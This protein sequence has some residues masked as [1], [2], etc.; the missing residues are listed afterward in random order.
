LENAYLKDTISQNTGGQVVIP[1][2]EEL[3]KY[4]GKIQ[5]VTG[6]AMSPQMQ[7]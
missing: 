2:P 7:T 1:S 3:T 4:K 5:P 6:M